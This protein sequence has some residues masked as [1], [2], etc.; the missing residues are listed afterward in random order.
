M[1]F[2]LA[3]SSRSWSGVLSCNSLAFIAFF[4]STSRAGRKK[5]VTLIPVESMMKGPYRPAGLLW[6][7]LSRA[8]N[9]AAQE[10]FSA[11]LIRH[12]PAVGPRRF[13]FGS[14]RA[15]CGPAE[16]M[17]L[18]KTRGRQSNATPPLNAILV[19]R[20]GAR[21]PDRPSISSKNL[22]IQSDFNDHA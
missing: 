4:L 12:R 9:G 21:L 6:Q 19:S 7:A 18:A 13:A 2:R 20:A 3:S 14:F 17:M 10:R 15:N 11:P 8:T 1:F 16:R 22:L 5:C